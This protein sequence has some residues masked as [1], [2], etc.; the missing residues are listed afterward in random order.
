MVKTLHF[1]CRGLIPGWEAKISHVT[2]GMAKDKTK[3]KPSCREVFSLSCC[4]PTL[5]NLPVNS[6]P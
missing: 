1:Y 3:N 6:P 2:S 5:P 4:P